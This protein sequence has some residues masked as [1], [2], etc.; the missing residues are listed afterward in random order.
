MNFHICNLEYACGDNLKNVSAIHWDQNEDYPQFS[1][2]NLVICDGYSRVLSKLAEGL[3][4]EFETRVGHTVNTWQ[5]LTLYSQT[6]GVTP[7]M[8]LLSSCSKS[9]GGF[10]FTI[11]GCVLKFLMGFSYEKVVFQ[12]I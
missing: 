1:G 8:L 11:R 9:E 4:I 3:D 10:K 2:D 7:V 12:I 6:W 5:R